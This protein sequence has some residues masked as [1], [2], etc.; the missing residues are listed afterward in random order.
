MQA[1]TMGESEFETTI[2][3]PARLVDRAGWWID[4]REATSRELP[5]LVADPGIENL[6]NENPY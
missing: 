1:G 4:N 5:E 2:I 3:E 6:G